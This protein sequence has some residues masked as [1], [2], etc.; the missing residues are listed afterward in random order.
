MQKGNSA[1]THLSNGTI[2]TDLPRTM[3]T[4]P[5]RTYRLHALVKPT[6]VSWKALKQQ[7]STRSTGWTTFG[8]DDGQGGLPLRLLFTGRYIQ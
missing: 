5:Q 6:P 7:F 2:V 4:S 1:M 3:A 8:S